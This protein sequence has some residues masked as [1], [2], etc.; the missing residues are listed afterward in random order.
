MGWGV[1]PGSQ[2]KVLSVLSWEGGH[3]AVVKPGV[4]WISLAEQL[5]RMEPPLLS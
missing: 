5:G 4:C 2:P 3:Q 1:P